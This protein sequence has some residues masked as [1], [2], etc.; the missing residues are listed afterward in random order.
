MRDEDRVQIFYS[1]AQ[2]L[3]TKID[4]G[5]NENGFSGV[6]DKNGNAQA[7]VLRIV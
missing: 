2:S 7:F 5:I 4:R 3:L 1:G 6:L